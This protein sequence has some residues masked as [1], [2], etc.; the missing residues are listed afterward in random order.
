MRRGIGESGT[1]LARERGI[2]GF[3]G[4]GS[5]GQ[6][7]RPSA[8]TYQCVKRVGQVGRVMR[9]GERDDEMKIG[10]SEVSL[11]GLEEVREG[12]KVG[13]CSP[14]AWHIGN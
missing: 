4:D 5:A 6:G 8:P 14:V 1:V 7:A 9:R 3:K 13:A 12:R 2:Q 11:G 10:I